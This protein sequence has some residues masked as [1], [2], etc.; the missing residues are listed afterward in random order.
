MAHDPLA[1]FFYYSKERILTPVRRDTS[2]IRMRPSP[3]LKASLSINYDISVR[4]KGSSTKVD[5]ARVIM[6]HTIVAALESVTIWYD[7]Y[8]YSR[9]AVRVWPS[10]KAADFG[11]A[12]PRFESWHPSQLLFV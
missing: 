12:I 11:S 6:Y 4:V 7:R 3:F 5:K 10:G 1:I 8:T 2:L 9:A